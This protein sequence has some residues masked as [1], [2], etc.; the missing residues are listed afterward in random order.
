[1]QRKGY[2][3]IKKAEF[4]RLKKLG[5]TYKAIAERMGISELTLQAW[6]RE[7]VRTTNNS[8]I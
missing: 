8:S 7:Y 2:Y 4:I 1:M 6:Q 5:F 3:K